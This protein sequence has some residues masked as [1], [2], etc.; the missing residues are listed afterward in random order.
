[1]YC[2]RCG[3]ANSPEGRFCNGCGQVLFRAP[4]PPPRP[5]AEFLPRLLARLI[6][7]LILSPLVLGWVALFL[8][9]APG[10]PSL[11]ERTKGMEPEKAI[12]LWVSAIGPLIALCFVW[13]LVSIVAN[14]LYHAML[15][16]SERQGTVGKRIM[17]LAV[18]GL[19]GQR[20]SFG[21]ASVRWI[22]S[23]LLTSQTMLIGYLMVAFTERKRGLH[24][25]IAGTLVVKVR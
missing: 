24:D 4:A 18:T 16:S 19:D 2:S 12:P 15:D 9:F 21:R 20:I 1:M 6:D 14:W 5:Y 11:A 22:C 25:I 17:G 13:F 10:I 3:A 7:S 23:V 8:W